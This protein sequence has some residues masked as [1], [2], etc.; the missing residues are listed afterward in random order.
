MCISRT[1]M[2]A[3]VHACRPTMALPVFQAAQH[4]DSLYPASQFWLA[5]EGCPSVVPADPLC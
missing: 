1:G 4:V 2:I 3:G 5:L